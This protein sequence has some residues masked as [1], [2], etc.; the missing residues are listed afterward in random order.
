MIFEKWI[1]IDA[2]F[3]QNGFMIREKTGFQYPCRAIY[4]QVSFFIGNI[5]FFG[6]ESLKQVVKLV[7]CTVLVLNAFEIRSGSP[8]ICADEPSRM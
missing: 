3:D 7:E 6:G 5:G 4:A 2:G 1:A 8:T